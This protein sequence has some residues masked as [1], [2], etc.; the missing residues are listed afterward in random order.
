[1]LAMQRMMTAVAAAIIATVCASAAAAEERWPRFRG[2]GALGVSEQ[3]GL[4][5]TWSTTENVAWVRDIEGFGWSS[6]I[7]L[8]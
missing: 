2:P 3:S 1:M 6:P 5:E 8:G 4:P 7:G